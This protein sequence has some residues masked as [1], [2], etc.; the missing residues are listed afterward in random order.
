MPARP[1]QLTNLYM[2]LDNLFCDHY[3]PFIL[4]ENIVY[5]DIQEFREQHHL[6]NCL[7]ICSKMS[8]T[9]VLHEKDEERNSIFSSLLIVEVEFC[10]FYD[11]TLLFGCIVS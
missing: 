2:Y 7:L 6:H 5:K 8:Y 1:A 3:Y 9:Y 11:L 10:F 4:S